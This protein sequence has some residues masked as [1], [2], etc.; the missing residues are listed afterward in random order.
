MADSEHRLGGEPRLNVRVAT[1]LGEQIE[2]GLRI[3]VEQALT[4]REVVYKSA[5]T[6]ELVAFVVAHAEFPLPGLQLVPGVG[7]LAKI[8]LKSA[9][10]QV[11][12]GKDLVCS[13][14][15]LQRAVAH[16]CGKHRTR[17]RHACGANWVKGT[18]ESAF[19]RVVAN[20]ERVKCVL[21]G[22]THTGGTNARGVLPG[23]A[24]RV[25]PRNEVR[26]ETTGIG[27]DVRREWR[28]R[29]TAV[30]ELTEIQ[31]VREHGQV[32]VADISIER[33]VEEF[34]VGRRDC[35]S[36]VGEVIQSALGWN[37]R[38]KSARVLS[39]GKLVGRCVRSRRVKTVRGPARIAGRKPTP[40]LTGRYAA[41]KVTAAA[42]ESAEGV[43][44]RIM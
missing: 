35:R 10:E 4:Q 13:Q 31:E 23:R 19:R 2:S 8:A 27:P 34:T 14:T 3:G 9:G 36:Q 29:Q 16:A 37:S 11:V 6:L 7:K 15:G 22:H 32:F 28:W 44:V 30:P 18:G 33:T 26:R 40:K 43:L 41:T 24:E 39:I 17:G 21:R 20:R 25:G 42:I 12:I 38:T 5:D 1:W